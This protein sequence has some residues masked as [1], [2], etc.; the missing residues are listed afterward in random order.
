MRTLP[1]AARPYH[2][3]SIAMNYRLPLCLTALLAACSGSGSGSGDGTQDPV[4][5]GDPNLAP[6]LSGYSDP[7]AS[8]EL[9]AEIDP[10]VPQVT[11]ADLT[12]TVAPDLPNGL[13]LNATSGVISGT[14]L[15]ASLAAQYTIRAI[16][17][18]GT[19]S[20]QIQVGVPTPSMYLN[21]SRPL[22]A[23]DLSATVPPAPNF[24]GLGSNQVGAAPQ[25]G[26]PVQIDAAQPHQVDLVFLEDVPGL[27]FGYVPPYHD[28][29]GD[30]FAWIVPSFE[31]LT[32]LAGWTLAAADPYSAVPASLLG[33][34]LGKSDIVAGE[35]ELSVEITTP[36]TS[37]PLLQSTP[38]PTRR[39]TVEQLSRDVELHDG[40]IEV[41]GQ[42]IGI[43]EVAPGI[44]KLFRYD[45]SSGELHQVSESADAGGDD[46][47]VML[48]AADG[49]VFV[50]MRKAAAGDAV[51]LFAYDVAG[52]DLRALTDIFAGDENP[53]DLAVS[54]SQLFFAA[55]QA[56][57]VR[58][59]YRYDQA[60]NR[61]NQISDTAAG[62][63]DDPR[64]TLV[65]GDRVY[66]TALDSSGNRHLQAYD[67]AADRVECL[68]ATAGPSGDDAPA[69]LTELDGVLYLTAALPGGARKLFHLDGESDQLVLAVDIRGDLS[70]SDDPQWLLPYSNDLFFRAQREDGVYKLHRFQPLSDRGE[71]MSN[72]AGTGND[73]DLQELTQIGTHIVFS[74]LNGSGQRE[75]FYFNDA[76]GEVIQ[77]VNNL[78]DAGDEPT[79]FLHLGDGLGVLT[80]DGPDGER[81]LY[82]YDSDQRWVSRI[83]DTAVGHDE[84]SAQL[85]VDGDP[86][87]LALDASGTRSL[88]R[89]VR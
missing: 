65:I 72:T 8:Y 85:V 77:P 79:G 76:T 14:P 42:L 87:F 6:V 10:N 15:K 53:S 54:G 4:L 62:G 74:S 29:A 25:A 52:D 7:S 30:F 19:A 20:T 13:L 83:A 18:H 78:A 33:F 71:L 5:P 3:G 38:L 36:G 45:L 63:D 44:T 23:S 37:E 48:G 28:A 16:N 31:Q 75:L 35:S 64:E 47:V 56:S 67:L 59:L 26:T 73:D 24:G 39:V 89:V 69:S 86:Y 46:A 17:D 51:R 43:G 34:G 88:F 1:G 60:N 70:L 27:S 55:N 58:K 61:L 66:F 50:S 12:W 68:S 41:A 21:T 81:E 2:T 82:F 40:W 9:G 32:I 22:V 57:G 80:M 49:R 11:G 84:A